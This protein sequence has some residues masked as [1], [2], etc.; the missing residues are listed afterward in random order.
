MSECSLSG[1]GQ[2]HVSNFYIVDLEN[3]ATASR[4]YIGD[5]VIYTTRPSSVC[6]WYL[7]QW[8]STGHVM[9]ECTL[10]ITHC[11]RL[12]L[13]LH[14][15]DLV[16][17]CCISSFCTVVWQLAKFQLTWRIVQSLGDSWASCC[18]CCV[19]CCKF[20][21]L[22]PGETCLQDDHF[23]FKFF[24]LLSSTYP[25]G[26]TT[27]TVTTHTRLMALFPGLPRWASTRKEKPILILPKQETVSG[28]GISWAVCKSTPRSRQITMP[29][30]HYSFYRPDA[31]PAAQPT[32]SKHWRQNMVTT[33]LEMLW[34]SWNFTAVRE[35][36]VK[37]LAMLNC[38]LLTP[39]LC[40]CLVG[41]CRP[42]VTP[43]KR[44]FQLIKTF[45]TLI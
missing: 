23:V 33:C 11:L 37:N 27:H 3:F 1:R 38:P 22:W 29:A 32:A 15:I 21:C 42:C 26:L 13:Q 40:Q 34:M 44:T 2:G 19:T 14:T 36:S 25:L 28:S 17:T 6:L 24:S 12:N 45:W 30:P 41:C 20:A 43:L 10:S 39:S 18:L 16:R 5:I 9:F 7:R 4:R 31:L 8:E 35:M